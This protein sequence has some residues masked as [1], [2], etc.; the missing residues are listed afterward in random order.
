M[1]NNP[2]Y[3]RNPIENIDNQIQNLEKMK[4]QMQQY[5]NQPQQPSI[6]QTFQL[7]PN[8]SYGMKYANTLEEVQRDLVFY[9]TPYFSKDMSVLWIKNGKGDVKTFELKEIVQK[10]EKD[11][12]IDSLM[13]QIEDLKKERNENEKP[14]S[15]YVDGSIENDKSKSSKHNSRN[16]KQ[17]K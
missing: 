4:N 14:N 16:D 1:Y 8:T 10:D 11:L 13:L 7:T 9:D 12:L 6:N 2:Y 15:E 5:S 17:Q 3:Y